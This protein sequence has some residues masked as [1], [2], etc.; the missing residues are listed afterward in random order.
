MNGFLPNAGDMFSILSAT[1]GIT[2]T[3]DTV[4]NGQR[5]TTSDGLGSFVVN[6]GAGST[7]N[8][9]QVILSAFQPIGT[10][11][12]DFDDDGDVDGDDL[13]QWRGD[14]GVNALSDANGDGDSDGADFLTWQQQFGSGP[15]VT[16]AS[17][18]VPEPATLMLIL[19]AAGLC[20]RRNRQRKFQQL[21]NT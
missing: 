21:I 20:A 18:P 14:F 11:T 5:L 1:G 17:A 12:A 19:A 15:P 4:A 10:F 6:Y 3:F 8:P 16:A 9:N 2:G 7:F 13:T